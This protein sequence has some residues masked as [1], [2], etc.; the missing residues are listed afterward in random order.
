MER[1]LIAELMDIRARLED[2]HAAMEHR[3]PDE[4]AE[5]STAIQVL[6]NTTGDMRKTD[7][8]R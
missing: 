2:I 6:Q 8:R 3:Y 7:A 4:R 1:D 5:V